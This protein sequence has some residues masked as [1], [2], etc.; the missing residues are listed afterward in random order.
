MNA[1]IAH[2]IYETGKNGGVK[3]LQAEKRQREYM[4]PAAAID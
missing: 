1:V 3:E 4:L 2:F